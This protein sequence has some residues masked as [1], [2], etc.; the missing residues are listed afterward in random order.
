[1]GTG[2]VRS[3]SYANAEA[4][5]FS[6]E[7]TPKPVK[8][9]GAVPVDKYTCLEEVPSPG[10]QSSQSAENDSTEEKPLTS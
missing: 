4:K 1:V 3:M 9:L 10:G 8:R 5:F 7:A 6:G 2:F